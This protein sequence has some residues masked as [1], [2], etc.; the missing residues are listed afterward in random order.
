MHGHMNVNKILQY[1]FLYEHWIL[2]NLYDQRLNHAALLINNLESL[3][4]IT[5][6]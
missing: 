4:I 3:K 6:L 2:Y 1:E 5:N